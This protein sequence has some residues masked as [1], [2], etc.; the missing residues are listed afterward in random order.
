MAKMKKYIKQ[1]LNKIFKEK[2]FKKL[3]DLFVKTN[4]TQCVDNQINAT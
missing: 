2:E 1:T 3:L 4:Y